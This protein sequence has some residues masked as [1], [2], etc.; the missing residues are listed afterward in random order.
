MQRVLARIA[1]ESEAGKLA[2]NKFFAIGLFR[3]GGG[4]GGEHACEVAPRPHKPT[5]ARAC[6]NAHA[7]RRACMQTRACKHAHANAHSLLA[8]PVVH[9]RLLELTGAKEPAALERLVKVRGQRG[10]H[11]SAEH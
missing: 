5:R 1:G 7:R 11:P 9:R 6:T 3:W 2:Y 10:P 4:C 8:S